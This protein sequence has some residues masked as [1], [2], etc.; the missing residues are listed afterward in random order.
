MKRSGE[1]GE[2]SGIRFKLLINHFT[3]KLVWMGTSYR[4]LSFFV[5]DV[6]FYPPQDKLKFS[7][8]FARKPIKMIGLEQQLDYLTKKS[9]N[10]AN[11]DRRRKL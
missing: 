4:V 6:G 7:L 9:E 3:M 10:L 5:D 8:I 11:D 2:N 1:P